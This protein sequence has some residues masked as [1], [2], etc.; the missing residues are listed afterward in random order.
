MASSWFFRALRYGPLL[1][2]SACGS[3]EEW[4]SGTE[5]PA[6]DP[7][8][9]RRLELDRILAGAEAGVTFGLVTHLALSPAGDVLVQDARPYG[10]VRLDRDGTFVDSIGRRGQGPGEYWFPDGLA[11]LSDGRIIVRELV[12]PA[13]IVFAEDGGFITEWPLDG[14]IPHPS[15]GSMA[16]R[17]NRRGEFTVSTMVG[18]T[19]VNEAQD[20]FGFYTLTAEGQVLDSIIPGG[21]SWDGAL[22]WG[23]FHPQKHTVWHFDGTFVVGLADAY[24]FEIIEASD[25]V[26]VERTYDP[27]PVSDEERAAF[28][29]EMAWRERRGSRFNERIP[30]PPQFK[31]AYKRILVTEGGEIWVFLHSRGEQWTTQDLGAGLLWPRFREPLRI[32]VFDRSGRLLGVVEGPAEIDPKVVRGDTVWAVLTSEHEEHLIA[33]YV[34]R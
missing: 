19:A 6:S 1:A 14:L 31:A 5:P 3:S 28:D 13:I 12:P 9:Q 4:P 30:E 32:D 7:S 11:V 24:H 8:W 15:F 20:R 26:R 2:L 10:V 22:A 18:E 16:I 34:L 17:P 21:T 25:T 29:V 27:V 23:S 33:R